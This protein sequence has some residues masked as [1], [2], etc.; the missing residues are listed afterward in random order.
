VGLILVFLWLGTDHA[1]AGRNLNLLVF[2]PLW[3]IL[4]M[5]KRHEKAVL[6]TIG[7]F[8]A[9]AIGLVF[10]PGGQYTLDVLAAF[11]PLNFSAAAGITRSRILPTG[12]PGVPA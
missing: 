10:L 1:A 11:L 6:V 9:L 8:S 2:N 12:Q 7:L 3:I 4:A 5:L